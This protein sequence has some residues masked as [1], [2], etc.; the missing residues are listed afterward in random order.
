M[1]KTF[2]GLQRILKDLYRRL[3]CAQLIRTLFVTW[4]FRVNVLYTEELVIGQ[5]Q[6]SLELFHGQL[7]SYFSHLEIILPLRTGGWGGWA[8]IRNMP[9]QAHLV[10][11]AGGEGAGGR[12][13]PAPLTPSGAQ[14]NG[15]PFPGQAQR[16]R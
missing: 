11:R 3:G 14:T 12:N 1:F 9:L 6:Q 5:G 8:D 4:N 2:S 16:S 10:R 13:Q 15:T 7:D